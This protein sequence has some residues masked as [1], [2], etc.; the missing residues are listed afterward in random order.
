M[1]GGTSSLDET[2]FAAGWRHAVLPAAESGAS[3]RYF[4]RTLRRGTVK[5]ATRT[6]LM[7]AVPKHHDGV[8]R[9]RDG[10]AQ[11]L[12]ATPTMSAKE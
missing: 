10:Q 6:Q 7:T 9:Q 8:G 3:S 1:I 4:L 11:P 2:R 12:R 5:T